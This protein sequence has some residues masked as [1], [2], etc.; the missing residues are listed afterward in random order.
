VDL[1]NSYIGYEKIIKE[2]GLNGYEADKANK[3]KDKETK[4]RRSNK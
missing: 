1:D 4:K 3:P 2:K